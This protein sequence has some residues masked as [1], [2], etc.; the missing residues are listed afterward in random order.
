MKKAVYTLCVLLC[1]TALLGQ[2]TS[3]KEITVRGEVLDQHCFVIIQ[4]G[5]GPDHAGC[6]NACMSRNASIGFLAEDGQF[7]ALLGETLV[8]IKEKVEKMAGKRAA[9]KGFLESRGGLKA[10]RMTS[11][12]F[13]Q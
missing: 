9:L 11:I 8:S 10:I 2:A 7:Y 12:E 5:S 13:A 1:A 3:N 4:H 6:S